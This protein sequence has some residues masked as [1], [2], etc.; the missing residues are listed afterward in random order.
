MTRLISFGFVL[1][2]VLAVVG[3]TGCAEENPSQLPTGASFAGPA[4]TDGSLTD[5]NRLLKYLAETYPGQRWLQGPTQLDSPEL[6]RTYPGSGFY[7]VASPHP[8][9]RGARP[10]PAS[11]SAGS[12][13]KQENLLSLCVRFAPNGQMKELRKPEDYNSGM[14]PL[15]SAEEFRV[16]AAA[17]LSTRDSYYVAPSTIS[18][19][20]IQVQQIPT[21]WTCRLKTKMLE[22]RVVFNSAGQCTAV[23]LTYRGPVPG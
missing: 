13:E 21:G 7:C 6:R 5:T 1:L 22:G 20:L 8:L 19:S 17:I 16:A 15:S 10:S 14:A 9:P 23:S 3:L 4:P 2:S 12:R 18:S 11:S